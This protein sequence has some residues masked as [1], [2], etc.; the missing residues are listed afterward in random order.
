[1]YF[2]MLITKNKLA[3]AIHTVFNYDNIQVDIREREYYIEEVEII[4]LLIL[5]HVE[6]DEYFH[7]SEYDI[8]YRSVSLLDTG[9]IYSSK[10]TFTFYLNEDDFCN[11]ELESLAN[12]EMPRIIKRHAY[13]HSDEQTWRKTNTEYYYEFGELIDSEKFDSLIAGIFC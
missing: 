6:K 10:T 9:S 13:E 1:M 2:Y 3:E 11:N 12:G 4:A 8:D 5:L 7:R